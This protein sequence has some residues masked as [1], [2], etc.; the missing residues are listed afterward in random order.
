MCGIV[1]IRD[2]GGVS[3]SIY[4]ALFALQHRGQESAGISTFDGTRLHKHRGQ[5]LVAEV[6]NPAYCV[7]LKATSDSGMS[8]IP[9]PEQTGRKTPNPSIFFSVTVTSPLPTT[10]TW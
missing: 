4:Y 6:F 8:G 9:R 3:F 10:A 1:G 2:A 5:G 7:A